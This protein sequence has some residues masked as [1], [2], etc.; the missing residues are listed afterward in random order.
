MLSVEISWQ[1]ELI[2]SDKKQF[3]FD[4]NTQCIYI[5]KQEHVFR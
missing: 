4:K 5:N 3:V 2:L 1:D